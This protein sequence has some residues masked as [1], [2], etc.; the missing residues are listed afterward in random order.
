ME[1]MAGDRIGQLNRSND[2]RKDGSNISRDIECEN[3]LDNDLPRIDQV[4]IRKQYPETEL[5]KDQ[6][7]PTENALLEKQKM[8]GEHSQSNE[9]QSKIL[10]SNSSKGQIN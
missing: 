7:S 9:E 2:S 1:S 8:S 4:A 5:N 10:G 6:V 3:L